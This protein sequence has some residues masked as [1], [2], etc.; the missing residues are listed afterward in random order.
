MPVAS[1]RLQRELRDLLEVVLLPA[2][3][4]L[5]PWPLA[6]RLL[7]RMARW[8]WLYRERE[9]RALEHAA[10]LGWVASPQEWLWQRKLTTLI[11]H[12]DH[13]LSRTRPGSWMD[14]YMDVSG[15]W[16]SP[17]R[18]AVAL[19]FHW[20]GGMWAM[21]HAGRCGVQGQMLVAPLES[22]QFRGRWVLHRYIRSRM[23]TV[24]GTMHRPFIDVSQGMAPILA[25]IDRGDH[26][27]AVI[28]VPSDQVNSSAPVSILGLQAR[29]PTSLLRLAAER[30]LPVCV[31][32]GGTDMASGRRFLRITQMPEALDADELVRAVF[33]ELDRNI[34]ERPPAWHLWGESD[35]FFRS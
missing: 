20:G 18:P 27:H 31:Y 21:R 29:V 8:P 13:Y 19:T 3:A 17:G 16:P 28:D 12:A 11:D 9:Q 1:T 15:A 35:R 25:A 22:E 7:R 14:R 4:A 2:L 24:A 33:A 10:R 23:V 32:V 26:V 30:A 34:R 6:F 5:L